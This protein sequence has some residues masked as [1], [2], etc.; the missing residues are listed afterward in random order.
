MIKK[1]GKFLDEYDYIPKRGSKLTS[2]E[3]KTLAQLNIVKLG[4]IPNKN[5]KLPATDNAFKLTDLGRS[6]VR[7]SLGSQVPLSEAVLKMKNEISEANAQMQ[8]IKHK[9]SALETKI[10]EIDSFIANL[11]KQSSSSRGDGPLPRNKIL[12]ALADAEREAEPSNRSGPLFSTEIYY[13]KL[14]NM[15]MRE[16]DINRTLFALYEENLLDL[17]MGPSSGQRGVNT[18]SGKVFHWGK[19]RGE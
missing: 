13:R 4:K 18:L 15:G 1:L 3:L 12:K 2:T 14:S 8:I 16:A 6:F 9:M 19:L 7:Q 5:G 11:E 17:Q 10:G